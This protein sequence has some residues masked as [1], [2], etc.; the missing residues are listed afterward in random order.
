MKKSLKFF[1]LMACL[2]EDEVVGFGKYL[3]MIDPNE[4]NALLVFNYYKRFYPGKENPDKMAMPYAFRKIYDAEMGPGLKDSKKLWNAFSKLYL[5]L[6]E[7][8]ILEKLRK[9]RY[10]S[11]VLWLKILSEKDLS[12]EY[13]KKVIEAKIKPSIPHFLIPN[14]VG[15]AN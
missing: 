10:I 8:L 7:F 3:R 11:D 5:W 1:S 12:A 14:F 9:D 4:G 6:K 13:S 15:A 2:K